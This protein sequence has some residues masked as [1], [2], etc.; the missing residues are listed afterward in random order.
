MPPTGIWKSRFR[1]VFLAL[2]RAATGQF[3]ATRMIGYAIDSTSAGSHWIGRRCLNLAVAKSIDDPHAFE[4]ALEILLDARQH[5]LAAYF[6]D[7]VFDQTGVMPAV[8]A[9]LTG[10]FLLAGANPESLRFLDRLSAVV[11]GDLENAVPAPA[12]SHRL[13]VSD[14]RE[15][16]GGRGR[17]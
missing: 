13:N 3:T 12:S 17:R 9:R 2:P 11:E 16:L 15:Q 14:I 7:S 5:H 4:S 8:A 6:A 1:F 10:E